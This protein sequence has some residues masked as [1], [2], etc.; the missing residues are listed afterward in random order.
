[1]K[2]L[3]LI[4]IMILSVSLQSTVVPV[5]SVGGI[6]PDFVLI[7]VISSALAAGRETGL[8]CGAVGGLLQDLLSVGPFGLNTLSKML[9]GI[10]VGGYQHKVN[11]GNLLLPLVAVGAG[12]FGSTV[13]YAV[14]LLGYGQYRSL[15]SLLLQVIPA[16]AYHILLAAPVYFL[17]GWILRRQDRK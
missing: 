6:R 3:I 13:V 5:F 17:I 14:F 11:Q 8:L 16:A 15:P 7:V 2:T 4:V 9:I 12:T 1:M 10:L